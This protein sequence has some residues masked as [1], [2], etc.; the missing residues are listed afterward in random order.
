MHTFAQ[1]LEQSRFTLCD[2]SMGVEQKVKHWMSGSGRGTKRLSGEWAK[3]GTHS[4]LKP[5]ISLI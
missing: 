2:Q 1:Q 4:P 3:S 5:N